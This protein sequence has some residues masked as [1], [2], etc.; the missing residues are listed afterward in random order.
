[1]SWRAWARRTR[2]CRW[3]REGAHPLTRSRRGSLPCVAG[4][5]DAVWRGLECCWGGRRGGALCRAGSGS[6]P[7][8]PGG[9]GAGTRQVCPLAA[10]GQS[11]EPAPARLPPRLPPGCLQPPQAQNQRLLTSLAQRDEDASKMLQQVQPFCDVCLHFSPRVVSSWELHTPAAIP[12]CVARHGLPPDTL[13]PI[14]CRPPRQ[15]RSG[16]SWPRSARMR[17]P[18]QSGRSRRSSW[19]SSALWS[20]RRACRW[21]WRGCSSLHVPGPPKFAG[22]LASQPG[23]FA[24]LSRSA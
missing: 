13:P 6:L 18:R 8:P 1:M 19:R 21:E 22:T 10:P 24:S 14:A 2:T 11:A 17:R 23:C 7:A 3:G 9:L 5:R 20:W 16:S 12:G 15:H 4:N